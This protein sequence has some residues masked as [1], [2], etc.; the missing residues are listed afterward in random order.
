MT[1]RTVLSR[2]SLLKNAVGPMAAAGML[3]IAGT[4]ELFAT[5]T[6][7]RSNDDCDGEILGQGEFRYRAHRHWGQLDRAHYPVKDC[8]GI[9]EDRHGRIVLLTNDT[10][11]NLISYEKNGKFS[12]AWESRFPT[13]H[14]LEI[15]DH[16]G[17]DRYWITDHDVQCLSINTAD[18]RELRRIGPDA[19]AS[20]YPSLSNYHPTNS[21]FTPDGDFFISD[22]YGSSFV[23]HFDPE[24]KYISSFGGA[25][26]TP[27]NLSEPH[28]VW[29]DNRSGKPS[30]LVC[31]RGNETLKW[32]SLSGELQR[33]V[34]VPGARPSNVAQFHR[35]SSGQADNHIAIASLNGMILILDGSDRVVSAV[36]GEPPVYIDGKLQPLQVFNYTFNHPHDVYVDSSGALYVPQWWSNQTYPIKLEPVGKG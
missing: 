24:G 32:F 23:H 11:N 14:G 20:K 8:H 27:S 36:G 30:V 35:S 33:V 16:H 9:T 15:E 22:G 1:N 6:P 13:A 12:A 2:R 34:P 18:G 31:D 21:A 4:G 17:E 10:H 7:S 28:A 5:T 19:V 25:G 3:T 26:N 29:I